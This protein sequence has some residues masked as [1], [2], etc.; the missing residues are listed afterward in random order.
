[1]T[2]LRVPVEPLARQPASVDPRRLN[3]VGATIVAELFKLSAKL[4]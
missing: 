3:Y 2:D 1:M 4:Q